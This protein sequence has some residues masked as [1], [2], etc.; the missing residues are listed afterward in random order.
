MMAGQNRCKLEQFLLLLSRVLGLQAW[1]HLSLGSTLGS[2]RKQT[3]LVKEVGT[4][5]SLYSLRFIHNPGHPSR[6]AQ[7]QDGPQEGQTIV[8][9]HLLSPWR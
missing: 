1:G 7:P 8:K 9:Y 6:R 5:S 3:E 2:L 4:T